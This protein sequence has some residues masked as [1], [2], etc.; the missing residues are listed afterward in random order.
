MKK[1]QFDEQTKLDLLVAI[2]LWLRVL[3]VAAVFIAAKLW[4]V[5]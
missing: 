1:I 3:T 4:L 5:K 2:V